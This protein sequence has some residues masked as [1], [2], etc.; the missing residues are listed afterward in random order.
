MQVK[1][2]PSPQPAIW[3]QRVPP[4]TVF[5]RGGQLYMQTAMPNTVVELAT[6]CIREWKTG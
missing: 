1:R 5:L 4:A 6:G 3:P 2:V